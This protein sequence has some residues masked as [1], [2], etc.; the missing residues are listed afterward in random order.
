MTRSRS[1][2]FQTGAEFAAALR[3]FLEAYTPGYRRSHFGRFMRS[4]FAAEIERE[5]RV[6]EDYSFEEANPEDVGRN[7]IAEAL[8]PDAEY[9]NFTAAVGS[10][11]GATGSAPSD[12]SRLSDLSRVSDS[13]QPF[14]DEPE[15]SSTAGRRTQPRR[16][17]AAPPPNLD[18]LPT[19]LFELPAEQPNLHAQETR[20][21]SIVSG[22]AP[23]ATARTP[24]P[25]PGPTL[26]EAQTRIL[27]LPEAEPMGNVPSPTASGPAPKR[28]PID[29]EEP[30]GD[31]PNQSTFILDRALIAPPERESLTGRAAAP[32]GADTLRLR[33][34]E[35]APTISEESGSVLLDDDDLEEI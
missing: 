9:T 6:L 7:L 25:Q 18:A 15:P 24:E 28:P 27:T 11:G 3:G 13:L 2:R 32:L 35:D 8:G 14:S 12:A 29:H 10:R 26:N 22:P 20:I 17:R 1:G 19:R 33:T 21:F 5:L 31:L 23:P 16:P 4:T 30:I 34:L